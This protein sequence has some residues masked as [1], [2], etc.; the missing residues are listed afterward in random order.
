MFKLCDSY[1]DI[2]C[3]NTLRRNVF[4]LSEYRREMFLLLRYNWTKI[5]KFYLFAGNLIFFV[6]GILCILFT[7]E[8]KNMSNGENELLH[9]GRNRT[10]LDSDSLKT[11]KNLIDFSRS[12]G[13]KLKMCAYLDIEN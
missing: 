12:V 2:I 4:N 5:T 11:R 9:F 7:V 6:N 8:I 10:Q 13:K 3:S 1:K